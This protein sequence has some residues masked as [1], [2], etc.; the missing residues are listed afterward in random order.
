[1]VMEVLWLWR[2]KCVLSIDWCCGAGDFTQNCPDRPANQIWAKKILPLVNDLILA[3]ARLS[4]FV[5]VLSSTSLGKTNPKLAEIMLHLS[6]E[7][8]K[9]VLRM[10]EVTKQF[11]LI[12]MHD[13]WGMCIRS[14]EGR[15]VRAVA[16]WLRINQCCR[17]PIIG[18]LFSHVSFAYNLFTA[19][20]LIVDAQVW[21]RI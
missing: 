18:V 17:K 11:A 19:A 6:I 7:V 21:Q 16:C 14:V 9:A 2:T 10:E 3:N 8:T 13:F 20:I 15:K 1:M 4:F 5:T 12:R